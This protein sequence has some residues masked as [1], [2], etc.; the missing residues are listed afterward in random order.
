MDRACALWR[1]A[2]MQHVAH[3]QEQDEHL[4]TTGGVCWHGLIVQAAICNIHSCPTKSMPG[5]GY[6]RQQPSLV[7]QLIACSSRPP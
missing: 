2:S 3:W 4:A 1:H 6:H 5:C 7:H